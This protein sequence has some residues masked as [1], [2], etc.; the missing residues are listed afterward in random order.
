MEVIHGVIE[1]R[2]A[3]FNTPPSIFMRNHLSEIS[4]DK[5]VRSLASETI[6]ATSR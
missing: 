1:S 5:T 4:A 6:F 3:F 2:I